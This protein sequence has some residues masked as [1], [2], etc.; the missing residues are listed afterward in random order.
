M[1]FPIFSLAASFSDFFNKKYVLEIEKNSVDE[2]FEN[3]LVQENSYL[4]PEKIYNEYLK[5]IPFGGD[6]V[7]FKENSISASYSYLSDDYK[8]ANFSGA[9]KDR[10][11]IYVI[12]KG[13]TLSDIA[14][15]FDVSINTILW[16]NNI[17]GRYIK[18]GQELIIL[19]IEGLTHIIKKGDTL[20]S[21]AKKYKADE[22]EIISFNEIL[23][24]Q[25]L[26]VGSELVIPNGEMV[27][28][29]VA[30]S[31]PKSYTQVRADTTGFFINPAPG[32]WRSQ[33]MHGKNAID[34][35]SPHGSP[36]VA[37]ASGSVILSRSGGW[38]GGYGN[39]IVIAHSNGTQ[40]LYS[41]LSRNLVWAGSYVVQGQVIGYMGSTGKSTGTH[42]HF[43]VRGG[44]NPF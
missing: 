1:L 15:L 7:K 25:A 41:H 8:D 44:T 10:I 28:D 27:I 19:P 32:S 13:D 14:E 21:I 43:E 40:T 6:D 3:F 33:G 2:K 12:K 4:S 20:S 37:V 22:D 34:F 30:I 29:H 31:D 35:A 11:S 36:I 42:L 17:K 9:D 26:E 16:A 5:N 38:N 18:P 24:G 39:Y 23:D